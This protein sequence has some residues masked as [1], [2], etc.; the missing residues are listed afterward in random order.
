MGCPYDISDGNPAGGITKQSTLFI[1]L[2]GLTLMHATLQH[3]GNRLGYG[4]ISLLDDTVGP[5]TAPFS[6]RTVGTAPPVSWRM[7]HKSARREHTPVLVD[8]RQWNEDGCG[9]HSIYPGERRKD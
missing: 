7:L 1:I 5:T 3:E 6:F 2:I 9:G 8:S 4:D